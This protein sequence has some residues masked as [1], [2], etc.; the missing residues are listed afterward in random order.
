MDT[1]VDF[2][3]IA[4]LL[5]KLTLFSSSGFKIWLWEGEC[6]HNNVQGSVP[7]CSYYDDVQH[8]SLRN[9]MYGGLQNNNSVNE[10]VLFKK[11]YEN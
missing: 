10:F 11:T 2:D 9:Y 5:K 7:K 8:Q 3:S 6:L 4:L 1:N